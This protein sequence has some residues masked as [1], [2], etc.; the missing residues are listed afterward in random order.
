MPNLNYSPRGYWVSK[1][2]FLPVE[3]IR[4]PFLF[5]IFS[6]FINSYDLKILY[7]FEHNFKYLFWNENLCIPLYLLT[8]Y[9]ICLDIKV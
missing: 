5:N 6:T 9:K 1:S 8:F 3:P 7:T 4:D 2:F